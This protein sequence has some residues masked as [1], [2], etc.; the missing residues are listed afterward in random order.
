MSTLEKAIAIAAEV[1]EGQTDKSGAIY[2]LH[3]IRVMMTMTSD[4]ARIAA[5]LHDVVEDGA[6]EGWTFERLK[7]LGFS[8]AVINALDGVTRRS[9]ETYDEFIERLAADPLAR[10]VKLG[11][12][13]DNMNV[14]RLNE[15]TPKNTERLQRYHRSWN[16]LKALQQTS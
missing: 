10:Q 1:H 15:L 6:E 14:L 9:N 11:D 16:K 3:P 13:E 8:D 7:A 4:D 2:I 5:V 12:L